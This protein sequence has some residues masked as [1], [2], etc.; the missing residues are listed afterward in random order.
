MAPFTSY[1]LWLQGIIGCWMFML[2]VLSCTFLIVGFNR[3]GKLS[4]TIRNILLS[5]VTLILYCLY[6]LESS[7]RLKIKTGL[8]DYVIVFGNIPLLSVIGICLLFTAVLIIWSYYSGKWDEQHIT[9]SSIKEAIDT[10]PA[11]ICIFEDTGRILLKNASMEHVYRLM[12]GR[13]LLNGCE[14]DEMI[15]SLPSEISN[16]RR[17]ICTLSDGSTWSFVKKE[18]NDANT[19]LIAIK[20]FD[21]SEEYDKTLLLK[22]RKIALSILNEQLVTYKKNCISTI[23]AQEILNAKVKIHD[24]MGETLLTIRHYLTTDGSQEEKELIM[25]KLNRNISFLRKE[26]DIVPQDE[27]EL[28]IGTARALG[29]EVLIDGTLPQDEPAKHIIATGIHECF[30]NTLRHA[31]GDTLKLELDEHDGLLEAKFSNNGCRP[32]TDVIEKGGLSSLRGLAEQNNGTMKI[33]SSP[34]FM[35][36][37]TLPMEENNGL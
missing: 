19:T 9:N 28:M 35:L 6:Q 20:A 33:I 21:I 13:N 2:F 15:K 22:E 4:S 32:E 34:E 3:K 24:E 7:L 5:T 31:K 25:Q 16:K 27:Y 29:V 8:K 12:T 30:T 14:L 11:G 18:L 36:K 26:T 10:L 23:T 17:S 37:I 1:P